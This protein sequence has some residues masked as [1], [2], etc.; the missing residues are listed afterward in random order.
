VAFLK[1]IKSTDHLDPQARMGSGFSGA[2]SE[3]GGDF[4]ALHNGHDSM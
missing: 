3:Y 4:L 2:K 1:E